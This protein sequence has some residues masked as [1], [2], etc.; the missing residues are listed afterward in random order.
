MTAIELSTGI[1][2]RRSPFAGADVCAEAGFH[3]PSP[4][5]GPRF[6]DDVWDLTEVIGLPVQMSP[7]LRRL[8]F[9]AIANPAWQV[10]A[11]ELMLALLAPGHEAVAVLPRAWRTPL[12]LRTC[13]GRLAQL[14]S[15][16]NWLTASGVTRLGE[17]ADLHCEAYLADRRYARDSIGEAVGELGPTTRRGTVQAVIDLVNYRELFSVDRVDAGLRPWRGA[18]ASAVAGMRSGR[19]ENKTPPLGDTVLRPMLAAALYLTTTLGPLAAALADEARRATLAHRRLPARGRL[20]AEQLRSVLDRHTRDGDPLP[21]LP[22]SELGARLARGWAPGDPLLSVSLRALANEAG[23]RQFNRGWLDAVRGPIEATL[24]QVGTARPW[25]RH[26]EL[27]PAVGGEEHLAWTLPLH[28]IEVL[29]LAGVVRTACIIVIAALSGMR[30]SELMEL[31]VGCRL[32]P[33]EHGPDLLRYRLA[34]KVV[35]GQPL[36]GIPDEWVIIDP[37]HQAVGLAERLLD[38]PDEGV[39]LFGRFAFPVR[40]AW[41]RAWVN[42]PA[43]MRLGLDPIPHDDVSLRAMRRTL[44]VELAYRPGGVLATKIHLKHISVATTEGY[45]SR[46]GGAQGA[47]LAEINEHETQRNLDLVLAEFRNYQRGV[48]PAGPG[49]RELTGFF[50]GVDA[51][52]SRD[53]EEPK[54]QD[55]DREVLALLTRRAGAL[56]LGVANYCWFTDPSRALCLK[57]AGTPDAKA[58]LAGMCDSARCPQATHHSCHR[59]VWATRAATTQAFLIT[60]GPTRRTERARLQADHDRARRVLAEIDARTSPTARGE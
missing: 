37:V 60:L 14:N 46:P 40:Y 19:D 29:A 16:L 23:I 7:C 38:D 57:L 3:L 42:G 51:A 21:L 1:G 34:S 56:H 32:P 47:L 55:N 17:V 53:P 28:G 49:A 48:L 50:A 2:D 18:S 24:A 36:G 31:R 8:D 10:V 15:L 9:T 6:E 59:E 22:E 30:S 11:K 52:L 4:R 33:E 39:A 35:K 27:I 25:G 41:F 26:A 45:A 54:V 20:P 13:Q 43:G 58:P 12:H 44:A 5:S